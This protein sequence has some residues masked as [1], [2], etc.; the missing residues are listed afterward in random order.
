MTSA[1]YRT[2]PVVLV[3]T[4]LLSGCNVLNVETPDGRRIKRWSA[5]WYEMKAQTPVGEPQRKVFGKLWPPFA[6]PIGEPMEFTHK[7]HHAHYWP[8]P[9]HCQDRDFIRAFS[10]RQINNGWIAHTTLY[11]YHFDEETHELNKSGRLKLQWIVELAPEERRMVSVQTGDSEAASQQRLANVRTESIRIVGEA[12]VP[13]LSL[14][15]TEP[16]G[17][18]AVEVDAI[19]RSEIGSMP[20]PRIAYPQLP[21]GSGEGG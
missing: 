15:V 18:P 9:Y 16:L 11:D 1:A 12:N 10:D 19:R 2:L 8:Y 13:P 7:Y 6:R 14:R 21:T 4:A 20:D 3:A 17:R 5:E